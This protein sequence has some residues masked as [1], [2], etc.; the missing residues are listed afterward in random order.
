MVGGQRLVFFEACVV[1]V[2]L[3]F[4]N[5]STPPFVSFWVELIFFTRLH[6]GWSGLLVALI[7]SSLVCMAFNVVLGTVVFHGEFEPRA[8]QI[9]PFRVKETLGGLLLLVGVGVGY[10]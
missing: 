10:F 6:G 4:C 5:C 1:I 8:T 9:R 2:A 3:L 7:L